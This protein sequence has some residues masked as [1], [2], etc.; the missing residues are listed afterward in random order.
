MAR[1]AVP[2]YSGRAV[3]DLVQALEGDE[4][5]EGAI[6]P[7]YSKVGNIP[8]KAIRKLIDGALETLPLLD[9]PLPDDLRSSLGVIDL[10]TAVR[11]LHR[12]P[13]PTVRASVRL[14]QFRSKPSGA[15]TVPAQRAANAAITIR[16]IGR[17]SG[18]AISC[19][20]RARSRR[21]EYREPIEPA[22]P[23]AG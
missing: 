21:G 7:I 5:A 10:A 22:A 17:L 13:R 19:D 11:T 20:L 18:E 12:H 14:R 2:I 4:E 8:P 6:V 3:S 23:S 1:S 16:P 9:D 15:Y